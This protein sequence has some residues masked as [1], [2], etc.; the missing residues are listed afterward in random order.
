MEN[1]NEPVK[2]NPEEMKQISKE[3]AIQKM[4]ENGVSF[5][6]EKGIPL[7]K[8]AVDNVAGG[9]WEY[10]CTLCGSTDMSCCPLGGNVLLVCNSCGASYII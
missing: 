3:E 5:D 4:K 7:T 10:F 8:E 1:K 9:I 6:P 2:I